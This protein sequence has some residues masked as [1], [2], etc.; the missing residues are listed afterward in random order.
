MEK[1]VSSLDKDAYFQK[2]EWLLFWAGL[3]LMAIFLILGILGL[4]GSGTL[5]KSKEAGA[6]FSIEYERFLR[7]SMSSE[8]KIN[9]KGLE[10]D[11]SIFISSAFMRKVKIEKTSPEP[12]SIEGAN[13]QFKL[14]FAS[15]DIKEI[16]FYIRPI[17]SG[18]NNFSI[19][20]NGKKIRLN[21]FIYF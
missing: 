5:S 12:E 18:K 16:I 1:S 13:D 17:N 15:G 8:I 2:K 20:I 6:G 19:E 9:T 14:K 11:S 3:T 21:Q 4:F 7:Y 10:K